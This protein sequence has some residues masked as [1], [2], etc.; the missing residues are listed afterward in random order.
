MTMSVSKRPYGSD[1]GARKERKRLPDLPPD[2]PPEIWVKIFSSLAPQERAP[3][4]LVN[5]Y[6]HSIWVVCFQQ[7]DLT[8][9][10]EPQLTLLSKISHL[11]CVIFPSGT[12]RYLASFT[13]Y[14]LHHL[15]LA[16]SD[17]NERVD[18]TLL[19]RFVGLKILSIENIPHGGL[20]EN[21]ASSLNLPAL[22]PALEQDNLK[23]SA[24][25]VDTLVKIA[26]QTLTKLKIWCCGEG[27][28]LRH[29]YFKILRSHPHLTEFSLLEEGDRWEFFSELF[30]GD[31]TDEEVALISRCTELEG[32]SRGALCTLSPN[33]Q[34]MLRRM[35]AIRP[36]TEADFKNIFDITDRES[37]NEDE[38]CLAFLQ[39]VIDLGAPLSE[40]TGGSSLLIDAL[41][42][43]WVNSV[44]YILERAPHL[45]QI[46]ATP[47]FLLDTNLAF[48]HEVLI[49]APATQLVALFTL[50]VN[51]QAPFHL[52]HEANLTFLD[53]MTLTYVEN[54]FISYPSGPKLLLLLIYIGAPCSPPISE[55]IFVYLMHLNIEVFYRCAIPYMM[56]PFLSGNY[57]LHLAAIY[58]TREHIEFLSG[59]NMPCYV[60]N[61]E[62]KLP[63]TLAQEAGKGELFTYLKNL[64]D[65][66]NALAASHLR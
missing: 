2:L 59:L 44:A 3:L 54:N 56:S 19:S 22:E 48:P 58:G 6:F 11:R 7:S 33:P 52:S 39:A 9:V 57:A 35:G 12:S 28:I 45:V 15:V 53:I 61:S 41:E 24:P 42:N 14:R 55:W 49:G 17:A 43:G 1:G 62:N 23:G 38:E 37:P 30:A 64:E 20:G 29:D 18:L 31:L 66:E 40:A 5:R 8:V 21:D 47:S 27:V 34:Q 46:P 26:P 65:I 51:Y 36:I 63:S 32:F 50:L 16:N 60:L 10:K 13:P 4:R 25:F